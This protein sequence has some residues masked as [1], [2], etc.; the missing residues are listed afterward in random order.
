MKLP[1][2]HTLWISFKSVVLRF[3]LQV[4]A[5]LTATILWCYLVHPIGNNQ[6]QEGK[7]LKVILVCNLSLAL[8][9]A[10]DLYAEAANYTSNKK[11]GLRLLCLCIC[12][13]LYFMLHP[14]VYKAD[15]LR[16]ALLALAFHLLVAF[17]PYINKNNLNG[18]W[19]YNKTLFLRFL[20]SALY[21]G[22]LFSGL[23]VAI[24]AVN[25]LFDA[26]IGFNTY[27]RLFAIITGSFMTIFF[28]AGLPINLHNVQTEETYPKALKIFT[29]Y[30]LIPLAVIYLAILLV[31]EIKIAINWELPRGMVSTLILG[32]AVFGILSLLLIYPIKDKEGN[33]WI[34]LFSK[35]FYIMMLPLLVLLVLAVWE[36]VGSYGITESRYLL[37]VLALWLAAIT[38]YFLLSKNQNIKVIPV[39]LCLLALMATYG[40]QSAFSISK[41]VQVARLKN[42]MK[43]KKNRDD[44]QINSVMEYLVDQ[45]GLQSL[46]SFTTADLEQIEDEIEL[47]SVRGDRYFISATKLD[48]AHALLKVEKESFNNYIT[49]NLIPEGKNLLDISGYNKMMNIERF[50]TITESKLNGIKLTAQKMTSN[51]LKISIGKD[52]EIILDINKM[53]IDAVTYAKSKDP[54]QAN[55]TS[56]EP[57][58]RAGAEE[59]LPISYFTVSS[60]L[61]G[62]QFKFIATSINTNWNPK[63]KAEKIWTEYGGYLLIKKD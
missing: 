45:H 6:H 10:A 53:V 4:V 50:E 48:T 1:S 58:A 61:N 26:N 20:T 30:V 54:K 44:Q 34:K 16:I 19:E 36:R 27:H 18:F 41:Y 15:A 13:V 33:G 2:L 5:A 42:L 62:Y 49:F 14:A 39:S 23:A 35:F 7:L 28:L 11:W 8:L 32:Y 57:V 22:V 60:R 3:P 25:A 38:F 46:Q 37:I 63:L 40:P 24:G 52:Q 55:G 47:K 29:Q 31:Y 9:L 12:T 59:V 21:A 43:E 51:N 56:N 17:A